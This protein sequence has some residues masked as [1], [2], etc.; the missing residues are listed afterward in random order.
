MKNSKKI[1]FLHNENEIDLEMQKIAK[2]NSIK[3]LSFNDIE[4]IKGWINS[5]Y[6]PV[7]GQYFQ[8]VFLIHL[9][10]I[11]QLDIH[12]LTDLKCKFPTLPIFLIC[13][14]LKINVTQTSLVDKIIQCGI[15]DVFPFPWDFNKLLKSIFAP[16]KFVKSTIPEESESS[17][18]DNNFT[19]IKSSSFCHHKPVL[20]DIYLRLAEHRF[21]KLVNANESFDDQTLERLRIERSVENFYILS[22]ERLNYI[23]KCNNL[24]NDFAKIGKTPN[25]IN[26]QSEAIDKYI[27]EIYCNGID[28]EI[29]SYGKTMCLAVKKDILDNHQYSHLLTLLDN[30]K[31]ESLSHHYLVIFLANMIAEQFHWSS[32]LI[33]NTINMAGLFHDIGKTKLPEELRNKNPLSMTKNEKLQYEQHPIW[34]AEIL[35][36]HQYINQTVTQIVLQHHELQDGTGFPHALKGNK[37][38]NLSALINFCDQLSHLMRSKHIGPV[39]AAKLMLKDPEVPKQISHEIF[40]KFCEICKLTVTGR[41]KR[42]AS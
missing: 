37:I 11:S 36:S 6:N 15:N 39:D 12:F 32:D 34:G 16:S 13:N 7:S 23:E 20:F 41:L 22:T 33:A 3:C 2:K 24:A 38:L 14:E 31:P 19:A 10:K 28:P 18:E 27:E 35:S 26:V 21:V 30:L 1:I 25:V 8:T 40:E 4:H 9:T 17:I 5:Y 29:V 42:K